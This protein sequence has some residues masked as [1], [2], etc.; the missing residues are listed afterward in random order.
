MNTVNKLYG[1]RILI[2]PQYSAPYEGNF[3]KSLRI[4]AKDLYK[5]GA[6]CYFVFPKL[7]QKQIWINR[8][9]QQHT[10]YFCDTSDKT[11]L[12]EIF[13]E[14]KPNIIHTHFE[15]YDNAFP[16]DKSCR[17]VWH[18]HDKYSF[19]PNKIKA[20]YQV[21][22]FFCHY[23]LPFYTSFNHRP[24]II[25]VCVHEPN[26]VRPFRFPFKT[27]ETIITNGIDIERLRLNEINTKRHDIFTFLTFGGRNVIKRIDLILDATK[28]LIKANLNFKLIIVKGT[29]TEE[30][31]KQKYP[32]L[33]PHWLE[34]REPNEDIAS[35]F[36][37]ADCFI[38]ASKGETF[39]YAIAEA[40]ASQ[41]P[42]IQSDIDGT[43]WN[44]GNPSTFLFKNGD[45]K[46]L[47]EQMQ[48]VMSYDPDVLSKAC[49][50]TAQNNISKYSIEA[51]SQKIRNFFNELF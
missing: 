26:F 39:S 33:T 48:T 12:K 32:N 31:I 38:S 44:A 41:L 27:K 51:Q 19:H 46:S 4:L 20:L 45:S 14:I 17:L 49:K 30:V 1:K 43:I 42:V 7:T 25:G 34:I 15:G 8:F 11:G 6:Q 50:I 2:A 18:M 9:S 3:I 36:A 23:G 13:N 10:V 21:F 22:C 35:I 5:N 29:D 37:D 47:A 16:K 24:A 28:F 40:S